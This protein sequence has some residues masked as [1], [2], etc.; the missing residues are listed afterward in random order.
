MIFIVS[1]FCQCFCC[2]FHANCQC[3]WSKFWR[4]HCT[5]QY[6]RSESNFVFELFYHDFDFSFKVNVIFRRF[7]K[8]HLN[9][10]APLILFLFISNFIRADITLFLPT[11]SIDF[12]YIHLHQYLRFRSFLWI[13]FGEFVPSH[14]IFSSFSFF[15]FHGLPLFDKI[16]AGFFSGAVWFSRP[17]TLNL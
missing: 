1:L 6:N 15:R 2:C 7:H 3:F 14:W 12:I 9:F 10:R 17:L 5:S 8:F 4:V 16:I 13:S 11:H